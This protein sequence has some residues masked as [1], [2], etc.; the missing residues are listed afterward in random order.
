MSKATKKRTEAEVRARVAKWLHKTIDSHAF[1]DVELLDELAP[2][3][4][5]DRKKRTLTVQGRSPVP[6]PFVTYKTQSAR[7]QARGLG[8]YIRDDAPETGLTFTGWEIAAAFLAAF[9]LP[10]A[11]AHLFGRGSAFHA[12]VQAIADTND[13]A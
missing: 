6:A 11:G 4:T 7:I 2:E 12:R 3:V 13:P 1:Y 10:D 5:Y 9:G 8:G